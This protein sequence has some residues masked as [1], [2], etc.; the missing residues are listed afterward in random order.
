MLMHDPPHPGEILREDYLKPLGISITDAS[1]KLDVTRKTLS[2][3]INEKSGVSPQMA[4]KLGIVFNTTPIS[5]LNLQAQ[6]DLFQAKQKLNLD[7][8]EPMLA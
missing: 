3:L 1:K 7:G 6:Y 4:L 8:I 5:W 2:L